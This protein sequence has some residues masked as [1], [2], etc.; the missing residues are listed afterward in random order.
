MTRSEERKKRPSIR[1][2]EPE[3]AT[4]ANVAAALCL[5]PSSLALSRVRKLLLDSCDNDDERRE[6]VDAW[7]KELKSKQITIPLTDPDWRILNRLK[8]RLGGDLQHILHQAVLLPSDPP[9]GRN[10]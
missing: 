3:M 1:F 6:L 8:I 9:P 2:P 10:P 5:Q 7:R 4:I